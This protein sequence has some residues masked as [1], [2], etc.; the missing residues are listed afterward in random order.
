VAIIRS[1]IQSRDEKKS[2]TRDGIAGASTSA[3]RKSRKKNAALSSSYWR[4]VHR[5]GYLG[6]FSPRHETTCLTSERQLH[7]AD[8]DNNRTKTLN[9]A[10]PIKNFNYLLYL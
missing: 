7:E 8:F 2:S 3:S 6:F 4:T 1:V 9:V 5:L 10:D